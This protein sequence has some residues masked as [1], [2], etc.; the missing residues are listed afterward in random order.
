MSLTFPVTGATYRLK[1]EVR[2]KLHITLDVRDHEDAKLV[3]HVKALGT[4]VILDRELA[5]SKVWELHQLAW[6]CGAKQPK[7]TE[8]VAL[9]FR[10]GM[11]PAQKRNLIEG[12]VMNNLDFGFTPTQALALDALE[13]ALFENEHPCVGGDRRRQRRKAVVDA[14]MQIVK[15]GLIDALTAKERDAV[16]ALHLGNTVL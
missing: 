3:E 7:R 14:H 12:G 9:K 10:K 2:R 15:L 6:V 16:L 4:V 11:L 13:V 5:G 1:A 8:E